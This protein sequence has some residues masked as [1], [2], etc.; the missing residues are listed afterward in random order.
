M[1]KRALDGASVG[2]RWSLMY[3]VTDQKHQEG[4]MREKVVHSS[5]PPSP[6]DSSFHLKM[7]GRYRALVQRSAWLVG[8]QTESPL[9]LR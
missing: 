7:R 4:D 6:S 5:L 2:K 3:T 8:V 9:G 1:C